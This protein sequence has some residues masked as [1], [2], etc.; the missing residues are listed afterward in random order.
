LDQL[1]HLGYFN[2]QVLDYARFDLPFAAGAFEL[3]GFEVEGLLK[4]LL[5]GHFL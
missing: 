3:F 5:V 1:A 2:I 4:V